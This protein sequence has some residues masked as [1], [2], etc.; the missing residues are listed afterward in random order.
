MTLEYYSYEE[1]DTVTISKK[2]YASLIRDSLF[3]QALEAAGIDNT[4]AYGFGVDIFYESNPEYA[5]DD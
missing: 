3:L 1:P 2:E 4:D 5:E